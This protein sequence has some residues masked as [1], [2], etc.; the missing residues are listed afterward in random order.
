VAS[1]RR[2]YKPTNPSNGD[3][4]R[5]GGSSTDAIPW[6]NNI[7]QVDVRDG[8]RHIVTES[9][10]IPF[11]DGEN[12]DDRMF[13]SES[14]PFA[15]ED[16]FN[17]NLEE[18]DT[19]TK[20]NDHPVR[21][22]TITVTE[23]Y[24]FERIFAD[25]MAR[26]KSA[27]AIGTPSP[28]LPNMQA[29]SL[30]KKSVRGRKA[31]ESRAEEAI[32]TQE[33]LRADVNK[34]PIPL[35]AAAAKALGLA[36]ARFTELSQDD[37]PS[38]AQDLENIRQPERAKVEALM[39]NAK[40]DLELWH[41]ME[42]EVFSLVARLGLEEK[43]KVQAE[44]TKPLPRKNKKKA[45][46]MANNDVPTATGHEQPLD[47]HIYGPLYPSFALLG[48]RLLDRSFSKPSPL[49]LNVLPRIKSL[50][51]VSHV[52]GASTPLYNELLRIHWIRYD[53]FL[54]VSRLLSEM[55]QAGL[56]FDEETLNIVNEIN[57]AQLK[58]RR[59][60]RGAVLQALWSMPEFAPGKFR[61][62]KERI[63]AAIDERETENSEEVAWRT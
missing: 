32:K 19:S 23:K 8:K 52:L 51:I 4:E 36:S 29:A 7:E 22:S 1:S 15:D 14:D 11:D 40:T 41:V 25:I 21:E 17:E 63:Q 38:S 48:L 54:G 16:L 10:G 53:D 2:I 12:L 35:R 46:E 28:A 3:A 42:Q 58:V 31:R 50:G 45:S 60:D 43:S 62:W 55:D 33:E 20:S 49:V 39:H 44:A 18:A 47:L 13:S 24:A 6:E 26:S 5:F 34:Y 56:E 59:G 37:I 27:N 57:Q 9:R 30:A 61:E